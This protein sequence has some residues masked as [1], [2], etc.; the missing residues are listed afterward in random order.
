MLNW[1]F[2]SP[3]MPQV[4]HLWQVVSNSSP[5]EPPCTPYPNHQDRKIETYQLF[6]LESTVSSENTWKLCIYTC[7]IP[8]PNSHKSFFFSDIFILYHQQKKNFNSKMKPAC[9][10]S[11]VLSISN[12]GPTCSMLSRLRGFEATPELNTQKLHLLRTLK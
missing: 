6:R 7:P 5:S 10:T 9:S 12:V 4:A 1:L 8:K 11:V 3:N 2:I